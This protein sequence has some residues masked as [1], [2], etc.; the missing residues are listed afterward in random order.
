MSEFIK[1]HHDK[2]R[3]MISVDLSKLRLAINSIEASIRLLNSER[4]KLIEQIDEI[5][6][7]GG[8]K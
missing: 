5:V 6:V 7:E 3:L 2:D 8:D 1:E 4:I